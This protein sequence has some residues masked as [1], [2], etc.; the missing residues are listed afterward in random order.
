M[1][2]DQQE[3]VQV[4]LKNASKAG[5]EYTIDLRI[6]SPESLSY[7]FSQISPT[8]ALVKLAKAKGL[9]LIAV[10]NFYT[11]KTVD[12]TKVEAEK[13]GLKFIPGVSIR[14]AIPGCDDIPLTILFPETFTGAQISDFLK[15]FEIP[16]RYANKSDYILK[17]NIFDIIKVVTKL[18]GLIFP[19]KVD[20]TPSGKMAIRALV[21]NYGFRA[22]DLANYDETSNLFLE[23]WMG[24]NF[25]LFSFS[26]TRFLAQ[27]GN[28]STI[29]SLS[30]PSFAGLKQL[31]AQY[32][33]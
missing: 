17:A 30:E 22:F 19:S 25:L 11:G 5:K 1:S 18:G 7:G 29:V 13:I 24:H 2:W 9:D 31:F 8:A 28:K 4:R 10:T 15:L 21:E 16:S 27:I 14:V 6:N 23:R 20:K 3:S 33:R 26:D 32:I 12:E